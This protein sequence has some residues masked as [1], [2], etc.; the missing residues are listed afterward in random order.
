MNDAFVPLQPLKPGA[1][2][3][4]GGFAA[5]QANGLPSVK[6]DAGKNGNGAS[7]ACGKPVV[8]LQRNGDTIASIRIQCGCGQVID[9]NCVY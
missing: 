3:A 6:S 8:T 9:L 1:T 2:P 5:L 7:E 4:A